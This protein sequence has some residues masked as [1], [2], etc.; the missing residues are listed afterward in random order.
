M[1]IT[2]YLL[3]G[4]DPRPI[5]DLCGY[6]VMLDREHDE[7]LGHDEYFVG[8]DRESLEPGE[9]DPFDRE[10][11][12][13]VIGWIEG[14]YPDSYCILSG[15]GAWDMGEIRR[16]TEYRE[17]YAKGQAARKECYE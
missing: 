15:S 12:I 7:Y 17:Y 8:V 14:Y 16:S 2:I 1:E 5:Q 4:D 13:P 9:D 6:D 3:P 10:D 11:C